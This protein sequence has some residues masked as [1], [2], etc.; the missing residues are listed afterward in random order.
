MSQQRR[1]A[2]AAF[3]ALSVLFGKLPAAL[4]I[5]AFFKEF[6]EKY[7]KADATDEQ[8]AA[9]AELVT[10]KVKCN[11]CHM[12]NSKKMRNAYGTQLSELLKKDNFKAPRLKAEPDACKAEI[13]EAFD[14]VAAMKSG[15]DDSPTFGELIA[16][17]KLPASGAAP[18]EQ[19]STPAPEPMPEPNSPEPAP[20]T[21][22]PAA[23]A[24]P[25]AVAAIE[26]IGGT[27]MPLAMNDDSLVVDFH[28]GGTALTDDGLAHVK[29]LPK[30][31]E[32][33]LK[34]T[35]ITDA[36][37]AQLAELGTLVRLHL[38][39]TKVTDA[40]LEHL[41]SLGNLEYLNLYGTAVTD[42]GL[43]HLKGLG[44]LQKLYLW[45]S[46]ATDDG[47]AKFKEAMPNVTV[48]K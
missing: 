11:V 18:T 17:G 40:G 27:V 6:Q 44:K 34:D 30:V 45:Q 48:V 15:G 2:L 19:A 1:F 47:I 3:L 22:A 41:K 8:D 33:N 5:P 36:G 35:Q 16:E 31:Y 12:G 28:L 13:N 4:A 29:V 9:F 43:E 20:A 23:P 26:A 10:K 24:N 21:D 37:L 46:Q 42:A 38:E 39:K 32:L 25:E 7:V 14:K